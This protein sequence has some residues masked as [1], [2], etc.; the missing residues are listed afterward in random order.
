M[1]LLSVR[2]HLRK[3]RL[4]MAKQ[5]QGQT[6]SRD[7]R[8]AQRVAH[9]LQP[10]DMKTEHYQY[11]IEAV[12]GHQ[13][14]AL[15]CASGAGDLARLCGKGRCCGGSSLFGIGGR[16]RGGRI[17][18]RRDAFGRCGAQGT[19]GDS[20]VSIA[21]RCRSGRAS[22]ASRVAL[23]A[24]ALL[25]GEGRARRSGGAAQRAVRRERRW[26]QLERCRPPVV[27]SR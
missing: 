3:E 26:R 14:W 2:K 11:G 22:R 5:L 10:K 25:G 13:A 24:A 15:F 17:G 18:I 19:G 21:T 6:P 9:L 1:K 7:E 12:D 23:G 20:A 16:Y 8:F 27:F 4:K